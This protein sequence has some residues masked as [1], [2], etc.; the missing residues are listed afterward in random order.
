MKIVQGLFIALLAGVLS[1]GSHLAASAL[2][3]AQELPSLESL[4]ALTF[5]TTSQVFARDGTTRI[6]V[7]VPVVAMTLSTVFENYRWS[8]LAA[9]GAALA[10]VGM[11]VALRSRQVPPPMPESNPLNPSR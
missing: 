4:D 9:A 6:G 5:S 2:Q 11:V 3:W 1:V 7:L 8:W 10:L